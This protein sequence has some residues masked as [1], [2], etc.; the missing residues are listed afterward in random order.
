MKT[1]SFASGCAAVCCALAVALPGRTAAAIDDQQFN[2]LKEMINKLGQKVEKQDQRIE[3]LEKT[4][5]QDSQVHEQD[6]KTHEQDQQRIQELEKKLGETQRTVSDVQE[7]A[8]MGVP[9]EPL[10]RMPLDEATVNHNFSI[11]G[12]AEV[13]YAKTSGQ[14]GTFLFADFAPIF[15]YRGGE[16][17]LFEAGFD[18]ILQNNA[19]ASSGRTT[20][21]NLS[22]AQLNYLMNDYVTLSAGN[23][24]LPLG[25]YSERTA[26]WLNKIPD[27]PLPRALLPGSGVG[28]ELRGAVP[29]GEM[30]KMLN[31]SVWGVNGPSS[32]DGTG[33]AGALDLGGNV[34]LRLD[35][36]VANLHGNPSGG[37]R[38]GLFMPFKPHYD[39]E[40]GLSGQSGE[41]DDAGQHTWS[42]AV[43]DASLHLGSS[44]EVKGEYMR[45]WYGSDDGGVVHP[46]G[47]WV[48]A[49]YKLAG[50]NLDWP[51]INNV[52]LV[53]RY[54][55]VHDGLGL[56]TRRY[57]VGYIYYIS[58]TL[59][60]E[61]D[62]EFLHS[63]DP[64][65]KDRLVF[66]LSYGF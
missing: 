25:T 18:F 53:N 65:E 1:R 37:A 17:V 10:P 22:F 34:G 60:F 43:A 21:V 3:Q 45:S 15:L 66:Q 57:T 7:K 63:N 23:L 64:G 41:W 51:F 49:G 42:A 40:L 12:D 48:Q 39:V 58:N 26:G 44:F 59:L 52:E 29:L 47:W 61:G 14:H 16:K 9:A 55:T 36:A 31:Y 4:H 11:L 28:A 46:E 33:N 5:A 35:N 32:A 6:Q 19:P 54:D 50:L 30:G 27:D 56:K 24:L 13:Q 2:E 20:T 38:V 8:T 62:Y